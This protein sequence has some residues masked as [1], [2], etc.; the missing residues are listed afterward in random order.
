MSEQQEQ[1]LHEQ[2]ER[3]RRQRYHGVLQLERMAQRL[4]PD[5]LP[6][7]PPLPEGVSQEA[8]D[9][10]QLWGWRSMN[11]NHNSGMWESVSP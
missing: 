7:Q 9:R 3:G 4:E 8:Y 2:V 1:P 5:A 11:W 10:A 6:S